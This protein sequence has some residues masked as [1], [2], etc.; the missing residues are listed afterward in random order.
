[1]KYQSVTYIGPLLRP[2]GTMKF[3]ATSASPSRATGSIQKGVSPHSTPWAPR[4]IGR[5][6]CFARSRSQG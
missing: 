5:C 3:T 1:M 6:H 2:I 4:F